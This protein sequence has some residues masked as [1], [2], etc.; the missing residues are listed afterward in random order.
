MRNIP[1]L[2]LDV[3]GGFLLGLG[4][5]FMLGCEFRN[6]GR[7]GLLYI[8][9]LLIWPYLLSGLPALRAGQGLLGQHLA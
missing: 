9:G 4:T 3:F 8:T 2:P 5:I 7:T 6:Y 1:N